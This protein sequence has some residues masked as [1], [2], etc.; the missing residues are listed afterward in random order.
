LQ[1]INL[2][3]ENRNNL[4]IASADTALKIL[5]KQDISPDVVFSF[6]VQNHSYLHFTGIK[7]DFRLFTDFTSPLRIGNKQTLLFSNHPFN[8]IFKKAGWDLYYLPSDSK[9]IGGAMIGFFKMYFSSYPV[10][11]V[12]IDFAYYKYYGYSKGSFIDEYI[13]NNSSFFYPENIINA[14][15]YYKNKFVVKKNDW[16]STTVMD[17]YNRESQNSNIYTL[18]DS[19]FTQFKKIKNINMLIEEAEKLPEKILNFKSRAIKKNDFMKIIIEEIDKNPLILKSY[20][21]STGE[22]FERNKI[23]KLINKYFN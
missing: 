20:Y 12:G 23:N 13:L 7:N 11:T 5:L 8:I 14:G 3:K 22:K 15:F 10:V 19:P 17:Q 21:L 9:N 18:S 16:L 4:F 2:I 6:D 1:N